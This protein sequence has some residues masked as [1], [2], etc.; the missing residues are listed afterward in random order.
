[1]NKNGVGVGQVFVFM[2]AALTFSLVMIFGYRAVSGFV[3]SGEEVAFVQFK[4]DLETSIKR[5]HTEYGAVR[6]E[7]FH[8][9]IKYTKICFIDL[10]SGLDESSKEEICQRNSLAD[11]IVCG[12][13]K[14]ARG[15][16]N[17]DE[18]VF[19]T[20][21]AQIKIKVFK[22]AMS[23]SLLCVPIQNGAFSL[24]L[25]GRGSDTFLLL[26]SPQS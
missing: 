24:R 12:A 3:K 22:I 8:V 16:E 14:E 26:P 13:W 18:N 10:D 15:Y 1:M 21:P 9:P 7:Q 19:L 23:D 25:E 4:T 6:I 20:P 17:S 11:P 2:V 5:I